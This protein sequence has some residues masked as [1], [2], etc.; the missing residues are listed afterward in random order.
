MSSVFETRV[1]VGLLVFAL[2]LICSEQGLT[3]CVGFLF[4]ISTGIV[5]QRA[6]D[7]RKEADHIMLA[8]TSLLFTAWISKPIGLA[9]IYQSG[10]DGSYK[11][12]T[13]ILV[14]YCLALR[15]HVQR[16]MRD[17]RLQSKLQRSTLA[18]TIIAFI[19]SLAQ[20]YFISNHI[21]TVAAPLSS[22]GLLEGV[23]R[24]TSAQLVA[25]LFLALGILY[26]SPTHTQ[27]ALFVSSAFGLWTVVQIDEYRSSHVFLSA[28]VSFA[29]AW[30]QLRNTQRQFFG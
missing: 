23:V 3:S 15:D 16:D 28:I 30:L 22:S 10:Q 27:V 6:C 4:A 13:G 5:I 26:K 29:S 21:D 9:A 11:V 8:H 20:F 19:L 17:Y 1:V 12:L 7:I 14:I 18:L 24:D 2:L 25:C